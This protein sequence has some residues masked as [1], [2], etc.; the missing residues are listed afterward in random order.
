M[1]IH[2]ASIYI[3]VAKKEKKKQL[4]SNIKYHM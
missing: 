4:Q 3:D 1:Y 2:L